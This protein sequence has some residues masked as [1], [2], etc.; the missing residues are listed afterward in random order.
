[1]IPSTSVPKLDFSLVFLYVYLSYDFF[2][3]TTTNSTAK[4]YDLLLFTDS[5]NIRLLC[6]SVNEL[7]KNFSNSLRKRNVLNSKLINYDIFFS[8]LLNIILACFLS[9][10]HKSCVLL[11]HLLHLSPIVIVAAFF[12]AQNTTLSDYLHSFVFFSFRQYF[13]PW[14]ACASLINFVCLFLHFCQLRYGLEL[15]SIAGSFRDLSTVFSSRS[16]SLNFFVPLSFSRSVIYAPTVSRCG[17]P[18]FPSLLIS[19]YSIFLLVAS[20]LACVCFLSNEK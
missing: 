16:L 12:A 19:K 18:S 17:F 5:R 15:S 10:D 20:I 7:S 8:I 2:S 1:M 4:N 11:L 9:F 6:V 14:S 13:L 3:L